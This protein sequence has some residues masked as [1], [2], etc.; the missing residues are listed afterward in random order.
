MRKI[1]IVGSPGSGKTTLSAGLFY[2]LKILRK[3]V[4]LVPELIKY[5]VY[6]E[7][8]FNAPG[9]DIQNTLEQRELEEGLE[10]S[11]RSARSIDYLI[12][13]APLCN[14]YFYASFYGKDDEC[15]VLRKIAK[16]KLQ[17]Y[18]IVFFVERQAGQEYVTL[19]RKESDAEAARV[20]RHIRAELD[21]L[22]PKGRVLYV[23]QSTNIHEIVNAILETNLKT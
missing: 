20:E 8:N 4:E 11:G 3:H 2:H 14:G 5:K 22:L 7:L 16:D 13:E 21:V 17:T 12:C 10:R 15:A 9:F 23:T 6:K 19:G 18:D 1:A